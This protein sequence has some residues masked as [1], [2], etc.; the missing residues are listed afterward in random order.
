MAL[1][2][3]RKREKRKVKLSH[4]ERNEAIQSRIKLDHVACARDDDTIKNNGFIGSK[5]KRKVKLKN[6]ME[7]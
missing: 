2:E 1:L 7:F 5:K 6:L 3:V 4:D